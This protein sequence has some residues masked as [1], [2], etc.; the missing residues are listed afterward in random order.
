MDQCDDR[1]V[2]L[3][4]AVAVVLLLWFATPRDG[5][6]FVR[7]QTRTDGPRQRYWQQAGLWELAGLGILLALF[8]ATAV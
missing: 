6:L 3:V 5:R 2:L 7:R 1:L 4:L 8:V